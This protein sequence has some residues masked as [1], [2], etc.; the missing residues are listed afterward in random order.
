MAIPLC[1][2]RLCCFLFNVNT[3]YS[4]STKVI[5][6]SFYMP[7]VIWI[8]GTMSIKIAHLCWAEMHFKSNLI[9]FQG[10]GTYT[11]SKLSVG[12]A[13]TDSN[14][15][16]NVVVRTSFT[17]WIIVSELLTSTFAGAGTQNLEGARY[18]INM[19]TADAFLDNI[20]SGLRAHLEGRKIIAEPNNPEDLNAIRKIYSVNQLSPA[21]KQIQNLGLAVAAT[22]DDQKK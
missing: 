18:V 6:E 2:C 4:F 3:S 5:F 17:P 21:N 15:S 22:S 19:G 13:Y 1:A 7:I 9:Y 8:F 10:E 14:R 16:E 20:V 11:E 12:M